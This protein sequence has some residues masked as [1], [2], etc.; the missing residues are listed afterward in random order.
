MPFVD[1][2]YFQ[3]KILE[4]T[5]KN[6]IITIITLITLDKLYLINIYG[7]LVYSIY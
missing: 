4:Y 3:I 5:R 6:C 1:S 2:K 7:I